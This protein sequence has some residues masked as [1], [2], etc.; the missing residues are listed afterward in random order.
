MTRVGL[1]P[2][3]SRFALQSATTAQPGLRKSQ[4]IS[5]S[6]DFPHPASP[7]LLSLYNLLEL[8]V[9]QLYLTYR[10]ALDIAHSLDICVCVFI[11]PSTLRFCVCLF[12]SI[13][14]QDDSLREMMQSFLLS[15]ASQ[16][17]IS[18]LDSKV[19]SCIF[20][21][22]RY[23]TDFRNTKKQVGQNSLFSN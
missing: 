1:E 15:T 21:Q 9:L 23:H 17:E 11:L 18:A 2:T 13:Q 4:A 8:V 20:N 16:Q 10:Y 14:F 22:P 6:I 5:F 12:Y 7:L 19:L 3:T